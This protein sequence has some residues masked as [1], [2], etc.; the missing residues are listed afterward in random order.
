MLPSFIFIWNFVLNIKQ[1][2]LLGLGK[3]TEEAIKEFYK[4]LEGK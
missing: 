2:D 3:A 4:E 1:F